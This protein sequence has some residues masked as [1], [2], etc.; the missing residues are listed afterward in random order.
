MIGANKLQ[1]SPVVG[2]N[3]DPFMISKL[4]LAESRYMFQWFIK[5]FIDIAGSFIGLIVISPILFAIAISIRKESPG[6]VIYK[7]TR[8]G[9]NGKKF[10]M[11]KFRSMIDGAETDL[12]TLKEH[13]DTNDVM[14][15][16]KDDPRVTKVGAFIRKHSLDELPQLFNVL[17]GEMSLI[18]PRPP[19]VSELEEYEKWHYKRFATL[20]G[21]TGLWQVSG[22]SSIV[23]FDKVVRLD[24]QYIENWS[25]LFDLEIF[26]KTIPIV[27]WGDEF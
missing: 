17:K 7:Q 16:M 4:H 8:V 19:L 10:E 12:D 1:S 15:K 6:K 11:Y 27:I 20:P 9:L 22:R 23:D 21:M 3:N 18:G 24:I 2:V 13:N 14:F 25:L 26:L 5:R